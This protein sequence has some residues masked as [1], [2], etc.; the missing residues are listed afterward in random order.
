[1]TLR[2]P[3]AKKRYATLLSAYAPTL[4]SENEAKVRF[5]QALDE[6]LR[7]VPK[8]DKILLLGDFNARVGQNYRIWSGV[9][10]RHGIGRENANGMR[11]LTLCSEHNLTITNTIFQQKAKYKTSRMHPCS[12][13]WHMIDFI[14]VRRNDIKDVFITRAMRGAE[15]WTDHRMIVAKL[16][17]EVRSPL[18]RQKSKNN[19]LYC[20]LLGNI[21]ARSEFRRLLAEKL[22]NSETCL[23]SENTMEQQWNYI[24][25]VLYEAAAKSIGYKSK[26]HQGWF[27]DNS[28]TIHNLL[29]DMRKSHRETLDNPSSIKARQDWQAAQGKVQKDIR[30]IQNEW[31][32]KKPHEIQSF[33]DKNDMHNFYNAI[34]S[35]YGLTNRCVTPLKTADGQTLLKDQNSILLR[36]LHENKRIRTSILLYTLLKFGRIQEYSG[37]ICQIPCSIYIYI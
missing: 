3:L 19:R 16:N 37:R 17:M 18:R 27:D 30:V 8:S 34:K 4:R 22:M 24:S 31:W 20:S 15:C 10:G 21:E 5:Y 9:L 2:I 12:K 29:K 1:M 14:M 32:T 25:S 7:Q 33:A 28:D 23:S 13:H 35:I 26:N 36:S 11:L 6:T